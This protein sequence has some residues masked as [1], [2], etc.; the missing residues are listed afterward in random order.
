MKKKNKKSKYLY[1]Y[2]AIL[3]AA[4]M[5]PMPSWALSLQLGEE[6]KGV[7]DVSAYTLNLQSEERPSLAT[8]ICADGYLATLHHEGKVFA[9]FLS[10]CVFG[11]TNISGSADP[12]ALIG[13]ELINVYGLRAGMAWNTDENAAT[14]FFGISLTNAANSAIGAIN[15]Q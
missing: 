7:R 15:G 6:F 10:P 4:L 12:T 13:V 14:V 3:A 8:G 2:I 9:R 5:M 11:A 1:G